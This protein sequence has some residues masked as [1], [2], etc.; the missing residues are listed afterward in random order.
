MHIDCQNFIF[1]L[2]HFIKFT[3]HEGE[4]EQ[5]IVLRCEDAA[6]VLYILN[7]PGCSQLQTEVLCILQMHFTEISSK[8]S[9]ALA[10]C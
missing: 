3:L 2:M 9:Q 6:A 4:I 5:E 8:S 7:T 1:P 10:P